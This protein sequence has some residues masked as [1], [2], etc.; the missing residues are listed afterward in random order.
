MQSFHPEHSH[1]GLEAS[2]PEKVKARSTQ[3]RLESGMRHGIP[4]TNVPSSASSWEFSV[5]ECLA[6]HIHS[7]CFLCDTFKQEVGFVIF[8][9]NLVCAQMGKKVWFTTNLYFVY[10]SFTIIKLHWVLKKGFPDNLVGKE[11]ACNA[12]DPASVWAWKRTL[13][14][15]LLVKIWAEVYWRTNKLTF[16]DDYSTGKFCHPI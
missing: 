13:Q 3:S 5:F 2:L 14:K 11:S 6:A 4:W 9:G 15:Q 12:G 10:F 7:N 8:I 1:P 16:I